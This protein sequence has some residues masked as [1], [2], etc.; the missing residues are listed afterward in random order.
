ML[1]N[2]IG[3][4][5]VAFV[6]TYAGFAQAE[7][8]RTVSP[9]AP[10]AFSCGLFGPAVTNSVYANLGA[11]ATAMFATS[12]DPMPADFLDQ[13][14]WFLIDSYGSG[15]LMGCQPSASKLGAESV[16]RQNT[17]NQYG[18]LVQ[19]I[20]QRNTGNGTTTPVTLRY[21]YLPGNSYLISYAEQFCFTSVGTQLNR[22]TFFY[23][24]N[25]LA[26][27]KVAA[28][29]GCPN[30]A[31]TYTYSYGSPVVPGLPSKVVIVND[32]KQ[33]ATELFNYT[34]S[35]SLLQA[36][37]FASGKITYGY[38]GTQ[39]TRMNLVGTTTTPLNIGYTTSQQWSGAN[40]P[41]FGWGLTINYSNNVV[42]STLQNTG[43]EPGFCPPSTFQYG[44]KI[45]ATEAGNCAVTQ[46]GKHIAEGRAYVK[47]GQAYA[48]GSHQLM[49]PVAL[50]RVD[51]LRQRAPGLYYVDQSCY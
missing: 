8:S 4:S 11:I 10:A 9:V 36:A 48:Q 34:A 22:I 13:G 49:G 51:R 19:Q 45:Q 28:D 33:T 26:Q 46:R 14:P 7:T 20:A 30:G 50:Q 39:L 29:S 15:A 27:I 44:E 25:Q 18:M 47:N 23:N 43:C 17:Y 16:A 1:K 3:Y 35:N 24:G 5:A 32:Q 6:I 38:S 42:S 31:S 40:D 37:Y 41:R 2:L 21:S 12:G